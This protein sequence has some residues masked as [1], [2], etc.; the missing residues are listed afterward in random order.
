M[1]DYQFKC[2]SCPNK[3]YRH[4]GAAFVKHILIQHY[5]DTTTLEDYVKLVNADTF[6][7]DDW[8]VLETV[9][10][11]GIFLSPHCTDLPCESYYRGY[12]RMVEHLRDDH[13]LTTVTDDVDMY[14]RGRDL[15]PEQRS[16]RTTEGIGIVPEGHP[17]HAVMEE[18]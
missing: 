3:K 15:L 4:N 18:E 11:G 9:V 16:A 1:E 6:W 14:A 13:G 7:A 5:E 2:Y 17:L 12:D 10:D 8:F